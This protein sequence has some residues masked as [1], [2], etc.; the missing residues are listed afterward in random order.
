MILSLR[1]GTTRKEKLDWRGFLDSISPREFAEWEALAMLEGW[2]PDDEWK[3]TGTIA[4]AC[5]NTGNLIVASSGGTVKQEDVR[6][7]ESYYPK[8]GSESPEYEYKKT[9]LSAE[10]SEEL[11]RRRYG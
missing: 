9:T 2:A 6:T 5:H 10:E 11:A 4:A 1:S 8:Y 3:K 7:P